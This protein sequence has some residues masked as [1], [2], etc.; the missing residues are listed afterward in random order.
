MKRIYI[1]TLL[2]FLS[3]GPVC[4][5][6]DR[7]KYPEPGPA[8]QINIGDAETFTLP[9]GLKVFV[10]ENHK[11][12][13][14]TY[15]LV[16][17]R[18]PLFEGEKAGLTDMVGDM[19]MGG[20]K[21]RTKDQLDEEIDLIGGKMSFGSTTANASSL[22]KYQ[23]KLLTLF[24]DVLLNPSFPQ[25]EL[26]K[27]KKQTISA[28][29][30][31]KD[32]PDE[33]SEKVSNVVLYGKDHPY[34]EFA[35]EKTV[36]NVQLSDIK[37]YY[38]TYFKPNIGYLAIV[39]D[40]TKQEAERLTKQYF[41]S[42]QK[43]EVKK[44]EWA[45]PMAPQKN[46]VI[47][48]KRP[49]SVQSVVNITYPLEL[50]YNDADAIP[51]QVLNNILGGGSA[52][53]LFMNL[54]ERKGYTYGAYS[55]LSPD[56]IVGNFSANASVRTEVTDSAVYQFL[57]ELKRIDNKTITEQELTDAKA[58]LGGSFGRSL[59]QPA[60]IARFAINTELQN[61]PKDYYKNY[62]KN[63]N[64][65]TVEQLNTLAPKYI[66]PA[67]AY[68]VVVG[69][70][71]T[72]EGRIKQFG[73]V[74]Y[75]TNTG[76]PEVKT[77]IQDANLTAE[78]VIDKYL[79]AIG[80]KDKL[81]QVKTLKSIQEAEVQGMKI[82]AELLVDQTEPI[83]VQS[84]K[85]GAQVMSKFIIHADKATMINQGQTQDVPAEMFKALKNALEIF[86]ELNYV[87][88]GTK[89]ALDGIVKVNDEAS[90]K[91]LITTADGTKSINYYSVAN[92]LK[93]KSESASEGE[94]EINEYKEYSGIKLPA[95]ST[96]KSPNIPVPLKMVAIEQVINPTLTPADF[97]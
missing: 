18:S 8:P 90:Y 93:L 55:S 16:L 14:V 48:V 10:V 37:A 86:P 74:R 79:N 2:Y 23:D 22:T 24:S 27:L 62:L 94:A 21:N 15:S 41:G 1:Y 25:L 60:T 34:G 61:L 3:L 26:D 83:A 38:N 89:L 46:E 36:A 70:T 95:V 33:I 96:I 67:H 6:V 91:V 12:P 69:N 32:S 52:G 75:Y 73:E 78:K 50:K 35:T 76:E 54:R 71:D 49:T 80:G 39:G 19:L 45:V 29:A 56:K 30:S 51:A 4:A 87:K 81:E 17:D 65:V 57:A 59:E 53:R 58:I 44:Q 84:M 7:T 40:I 85:M 88:N 5:Q 92:G 64:A 42:W 97:Q 11:L 63:L 68:I 20:T 47:L 72:F 13:R 77:T 28:I 31:S 66:K 9:N 82:T 43:G